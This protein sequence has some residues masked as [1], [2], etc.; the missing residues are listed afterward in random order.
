MSGR[1][2]TIAPGGEA[3]GSAGSRCVQDEGSRARLRYPGVLRESTG[4]RWRRRRMCV[5]VPLSLCVW[6]MCVPVC[7]RT[8]VR[9]EE[10]EES[11]SEP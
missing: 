10:E 4:W 8:P 1:R 7:A 5:C 3:A 9:E 2:E 11:G 6:C